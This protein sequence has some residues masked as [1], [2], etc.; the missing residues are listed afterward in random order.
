MRENEKELFFENEV[1]NGKRTEKLVFYITIASIIVECFIAMAMMEDGI[2]NGS[3]R[4]E[5][6]TFGLLLILFTVGLYLYSK[7]CDRQ[8]KG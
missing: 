5:G 7:F 2:K 6:L 1:R 3:G 4:G 8:K